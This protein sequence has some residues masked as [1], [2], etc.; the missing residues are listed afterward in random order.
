[1]DKNKTNKTKK[2][3]GAGR[4]RIIVDLEILKNIATIGCTD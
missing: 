1:M 4:P 3:Q 2:R